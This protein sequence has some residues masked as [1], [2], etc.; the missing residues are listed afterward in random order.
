MFGE[1]EIV[2]VLFYYDG[3]QVLVAQDGF[4]TQFLCMLVEQNKKEDRFL[5]VPCTTTRVVS[6]RKGEIELRSIFTNP[7]REASSFLST[8]K[9]NKL[10][11]SDL[12][13]EE[14]PEGWLPEPGLFLEPDEIEDEE[15][16]VRLAHEQRRAFIQVS[17]DP[18]EAREESKIKAESL[19]VILNSFQKLVKHAYKK[20]IS[21]LSSIQRCQLTEEDNFRLDVCAFSKEGSFV[22][23]LQSATKSD[24]ANEV[25]VSRALTKVIDLCNNIGNIEKTTEI[26]KENKGHLANAFIR[27]LEVLVNTDS[28]VEMSLAEP[29]SKKTKRIS[30]RRKEAELLYN[31]LNSKKE[32]G[33]EENS[34]IGG[35][36]QVNIKTGTWTI[37]NEEDNHPYNG[38]IKEG[39]NVSLSGIVIDKN[40]YRFDC[41]EHLEAVTGTGKEKTSYQ[42]YRIKEL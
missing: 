36:T 38:S 18:P 22:F 40:R 33:V 30:V 24:L 9:E 15:E 37:Q 34:F 42:L 39:S 20:A 1:L 3:P 19:S 11:I 4:N 10:V 2:K 25:E 6:L 29:S 27:F 41:E 16:I 35:V 12:L 17:L 31:E 13:G 8:F 7:E 28:S 32:L 5:C 23:R 14:I 21:V 26:V